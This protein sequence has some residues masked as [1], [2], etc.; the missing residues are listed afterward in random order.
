MHPF[1]HN[2]RQSRNDYKQRARTCYLEI[3]NVDPELRKCVYNVLQKYQLATECKIIKV[4]VD[5]FATFDQ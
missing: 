1:R 5:R 2:L 3:P 4:A